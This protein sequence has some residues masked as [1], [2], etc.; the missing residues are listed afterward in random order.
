MGKARILGRDAQIFANAGSTVI[1]LGEVDKFSAKKL[2]EL[3]KSQPLGEK[4]P[5]SNVV[6]MGWE[7]S[8]EGGKVDWALAQMIHAQDEQI[9]SGGR[10]PYFSIKQRITYYDGKIEEFEYTDVSIYGYEMDMGSSTDEI[11]EKVTGFAGARRLSNVDPAIAAVGNGVIAGI[12]AA[13]G[14]LPEKPI[15]KAKSV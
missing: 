9:R 15:V 5:T 11:T 2:D 12:A 3:K 13:L 6:H 1:A 14:Q 10:S 8:F 4:N 7:L